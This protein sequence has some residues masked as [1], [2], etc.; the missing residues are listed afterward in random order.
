VVSARLGER[1]IA[2]AS[3]TRWPTWRWVR[4]GLAVVPLP[5]NRLARRLPEPGALYD[6]LSER[7]S[8]KDT[9][10]A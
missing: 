2:P 1:L 9:V 8:F 5:G 10:P 6:K 7:Q 4:A 3:I